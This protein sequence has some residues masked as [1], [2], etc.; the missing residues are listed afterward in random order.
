M[1]ENK[2]IEVK[3]DNDK[4]VLFDDAIIKDNFNLIISENNIY[5]YKMLDNS[6]FFS[7]LVSSI[8]TLVIYPLQIPRFYKLK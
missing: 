1:L 5:F 3:K 2:G 6:L 8:S 4:Y 7:L